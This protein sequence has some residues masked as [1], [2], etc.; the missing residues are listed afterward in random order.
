MPVR[1]SRP[2]V[3]RVMLTTVASSAA[4]PEPSTL[5]ASTHGPDAEEYEGREYLL[6]SWH[7]PAPGSAAL[8]IRPSMRLGIGLAGIR[9]AQVICQPRPV[10]L[11]GSSKNLNRVR[12]TDPGGAPGPRS[13]WCVVV[14]GG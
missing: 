8:V 14:R 5:T 7:A 9:Q 11:L 2:M 12:G 10:T 4:I 6:R 1:K 3:G 13:P